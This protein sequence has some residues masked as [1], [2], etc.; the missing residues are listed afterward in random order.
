MHDI[1]EKAMKNIWYIMI[2]LVFAAALNSCELET[3]PYDKVEGSQVVES[4]GGLEA[5]TLGSYSYMK[6]YSLVKP[7]HFVGEFGSD[8]VALSGTTTDR[9]FNIYSFNRVTDN[10]H[11]ADL[12]NTSYKI[13]INCNR[14]IESAEVGKNAYNDNL[15]GENHY[16][17]GMLY[18]TLV[19]AFG[20]PYSHDAGASLGVPLK[21][22]SDTAD[23]PIRSSVADAYEQVIKDLEKGAELMTLRKEG[24]ENIFATKE[25]AYALLSRVYLYM[26]NWTKAKEYADEVIKSPHFS[27]LYGEDY[28]KYTHKVPEENSETIFAIRHVKDQDFPYETGWGTWSNWNTVGSMYANI[29]GAGWG[30]MYASK[31]LRDILDENEGDLRTNFIE[32]QYSEGEW[33]LWVD[34]DRVTSGGD[35]YP[36]FD[37]QNVEKEGDE[38]VYY[39]DTDLDGNDERF[40]VEEVDNGSET[41]YYLDDWDRVGEEMINRGRRQ[42]DITTRMHMR[43]GFPKYFVLKCSLQEGQDHMWSPVIS[44]LGEMFLN[45]AEAN[46][47]LN[48]D[49]DALDDIN[50]LRKRAEIPEWDLNDYP[51]GMDLLDIILRERRAELAYEAHRRYDVF[52]TKRDMNRMYPGTHYWAGNPLGEITWES[53]DVVLKIPQQALDTYPTD[54]EQNP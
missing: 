46:Y 42:V 38:Y 40:V 41:E 43:N 49:Q 28:K 17:R 21:L 13:I 37:F 53:N 25:A 34:E 29:N 20:R 9:L 10:W 31:S 47:H 8:N 18:F 19:N 5:V 23:Y 1:K 52:R 15:I 22:S 48:N 36:M 4:E 7:M 44:R 33:A 3:M 14:A 50:E 27:L 24:M 35:N 6:R 2:A 45:R 39:V 16:I 12:W 32:P 51:D 26:E 54:L 30:E 11:V